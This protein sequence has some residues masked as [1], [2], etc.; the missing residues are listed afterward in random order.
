MIIVVCAEQGGVGK[1][2]L[3]VHLVAQ[4]ALAGHDVLL[5]DTAL[6]VSVSLWAQKRHEAI[7][8]PR[9]ACVQQFGQ[10]LQAEVRD[11]AWWPRLRLFMPGSRL[12]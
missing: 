8:Q 6:Q 9:V 10:G 7:I 11:L 4:R 5:V 1:T 2:T 12:A 3:A